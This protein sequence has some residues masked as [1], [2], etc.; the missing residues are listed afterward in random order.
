MPKVSIVTC[1]Y[2][3]PDFLREAV[4]SLRQ[5]TDPDWEHLIFDDGST[6]MRIDGVLV[7][8]S[9]DPRVRVWRE[10]ENRDRPAAVWNFLLD[11]ARGRYLCTLDDDDE[12]LPSFVEV[13]AGELDR[14][15]A[16]DLVT[17]GFVVKTGPDGGPDWEHHLNLETT[18]EGVERRSTCQGG[19]LLYR[20]EARGRAGRFSEVIRTNEDW[21]W[22]RRAVKVLR[23]KN[24]P[25]CHAV[26][27]QHDANRQR[28][29]EALGQV[30]DVEFIRGR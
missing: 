7:W 5:Q 28:R 6:D 15:P 8:A 20:R 26:Y 4:E 30:A 25:E 22:L 21:E 18:P 24:L 12:K 27:R 16:L 14:D 13:M 1:S 19:A 9:E 11:R 17:C 23:V 2:N 3:R 29:A 10:T